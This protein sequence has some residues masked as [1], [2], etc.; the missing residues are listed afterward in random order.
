MRLSN[1]DARELVEF[2]DRLICHF[3]LAAGVAPD[4]S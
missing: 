3:I 4:V 1:V 2:K